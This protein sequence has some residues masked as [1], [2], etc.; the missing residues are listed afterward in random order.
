MYDKDKIKNNLTIEQVTDLVA[1]L[2]GEP[3]Q[4][5]DNILVCKT[6][7]HNGCGQGSHKLYYYADT[8]LFHC[9]TG[10]GDASFDIFDLYKKVKNIEHNVEHTLPWSVAHVAAYFGIADEVEESVWDIQNPL[11]DW[12][13]LKRYATTAVYTPPTIIEPAPYDASILKYLP[14]PKIQP[15]IEDGISQEI[16]EQRG[17]CYD[18]VYHGIVIPHYNING[19]LIGIRERTLVK[20]NA[21]KYGKYRPA[22][23]NSVQYNH[24][25]GSNCYNLSYSCDNIRRTKRVLV[26]ESEK[27]CLQYATMFGVGNDI[28]VAVC[29]SNIS[30]NQFTLLNRLGIKDMIVGFDRQYQKIGDKEYQNWINKLKMIN[31]KY[32]NYVNIS[33]IFDT[34]NLLDYKDSPTDKGKE[35]FI[36]LYNSRLDGNG[37]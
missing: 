12:N 14:H 10:C 37:K 25:L 13:I 5:K 36:K 3:Q 2:G 35:T 15:W 20:E 26:F 34:K 31:K 7:C 30:W 24:P 29:G 28:S 33:F 19:E 11:Q 16:M 32:G 4:Q 6:I 23:L 9:Y 1:E 17:I 18:P 8:H 22:I 27:S 21:E